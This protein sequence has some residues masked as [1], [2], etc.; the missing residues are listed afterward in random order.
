MVAERKHEEHADRPE[1]ERAPAPRLRIVE[2]P[3]ERARTPR[4]VVHIGEPLPLLE[5]VRVDALP[6]HTAYAD[7]GC[8]LAPSC[9]R[10]PLV[11]C[12]YDEPGGARVIK[13]GARAREVAR[14]HRS[15]GASITQLAEQ[16]GISRRQVFR[17]LRAAREREARNGRR[18]ART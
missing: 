17:A 4:R 12:K 9:L 1:R 3:L 15:D 16:F 6:E 11:R 14:T 2:P 5:R 18:A 10:C 13:A 8:E 7:S